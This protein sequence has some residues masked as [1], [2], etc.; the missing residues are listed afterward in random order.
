MDAGRERVRTSPRS[1]YVPRTAPLTIS[2]AMNFELAN[3]LKQ[4]GFPQ[5]GRGSRVANPERIV[6]RRDDFA[7]VPTLEELIESCGEQFR[8]LQRLENGAW[9]CTANALDWTTNGI[10]ALEWSPTEAVARL[11]LALNNR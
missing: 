4:A 10:E 6:A 7:Y 3:A 11:W 9:Y 5:D 1:R 8:G 2:S